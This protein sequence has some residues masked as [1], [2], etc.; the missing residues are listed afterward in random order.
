MRRGR[1]LILL[2]LI[3]AV[4]TAAAVYFFVQNI[5]PSQTSE[6]VLEKV[7]VAEQP[8]AEEETIEGRVNLVDMPKGYV[9]EGALRSLDG[10]GGLLAA[11]PIPPGAVIHPSMLISQE[12]LAQE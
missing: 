9:P 12:E 8:I 7:V 6:I 5:E 2:G 10:I 4:G 1:I 11:G 3:L